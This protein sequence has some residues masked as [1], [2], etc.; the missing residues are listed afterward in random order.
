MNSNDDKNI[1]INNSYC[2]DSED[3]NTRY[4]DY[5]L[6]YITIDTPPTK[7]VYQVGEFFNPAGM[8]VRAHFTNGTSRVVSFFDYSL[9]QIRV[10]DQEK[11][12]IEKG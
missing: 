7:T 8:V 12:I 3:N 11:Q 1:I 10:I 2:E 6:D 5:E 9:F 4:I